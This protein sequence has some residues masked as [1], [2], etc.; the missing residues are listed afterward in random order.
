MIKRIWMLV[1]LI[2]V[3]SAT[4]QQQAVDSL[5]KVLDGHPGQD[6]VRLHLLNELAFAYYAVDPAR[7]VAIAEEAIAL[8]RRIDHPRLLAAAYNSKG[9]NL[10]AKGED[11]LAMEAGETA[12]GIHQKAGNKLGAAKALNNLALNYYN[13][14]DFRKALEYHETALALFRELNHHTGIAHSFSNMGV[15][16]LSLSDYPKALRHFLNGARYWENG[17]SAALANTYL[18]VGLVYK[19][20]KDYPRAMQY[21]ND[22]LDIYVRIGQKQG[23]ANACGN[24]GTISSENGDT[25]A[26]LR[27]YERALE[28]NNA[29][30]NKRRI[31]SDLVNIAVAYR[32][33]NDIPA[34]AA[35]LQK[36]LQLY[37]QT[38]DKE[39][40][41][42]T[43]INLAGLYPHAPTT[44]PTLRKALRLAEEAGSLQN[45][46]LAWETL[47]TTY[48]RSGRHAAALDA[49]RQHILL[50]DSIYNSAKTKEIARQQ[51]QFEFEKKEALLK[52]AHE[53]DN[54]LAQAEIKRRKAIAVAIMAGAIIL[55][56]ASAAGYALFRKKKNAEFR[57]KIADTE[58][59]ALR[60]QMNP[61]FIFNSLNAISNFIDRNEPRLADDYLMR[62][63]KLVRMIL[64]NS[65]LKEISLT[66]DLQALQL[67]LELEALRL[68]DRFTYEVKVDEAVDP[69]NTLVP[70]LI[71]QPFV[72]NSIW[73]GV[74]KRENGGRILIE[75]R[76][77]EGK[78][79]CRIADNGPGRNNGKPAEAG[80]RS[81][82][83]HITQSRIDILNAQQ[84]G[85]ADITFTDMPQGLQVTVSLPLMLKF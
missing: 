67:Y 1:C 68:K 57:A 51:I 42:F 41:A 14:S 44:L 82:G 19:N 26:A 30:G 27:Y 25:A 50:R 53:K 65:G 18:N 85:G 21:A 49:Y 28:L 64:E 15:V 47:S 46:S 40:T 45:Q 61:H 71:L 74:S 76:Q 62:F 78:L 43:L 59:K 29:I 60:A 63:S 66:D 20:M 35:Y 80:K 5:R 31:A 52:A 22:A 13:L 39:N 9:T 83:T 33:M 32:K 69:D 58:M 34:A 75:I 24:L 10:W 84:N 7:G 55:L 4:A 73:H 48:E 81:L 3:L 36:G 11:S 70:P 2:P 23:E 54:A 37:E 8:A 77:H 12:L 16:Y 6:T 72:E 17:D 38:N 79:R 56:A